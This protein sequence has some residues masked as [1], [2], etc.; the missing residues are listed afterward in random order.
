MPQIV[1]LFIE[2]IK[3]TIPVSP[4]QFYFIFISQLY[5]TPS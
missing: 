4:L 3:G 2:G 5:Y 1:L